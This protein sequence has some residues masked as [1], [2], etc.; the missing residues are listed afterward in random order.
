MVQNHER[1]QFSGGQIEVSMLTGFRGKRE[2]PHHVVRLTL[3]PQPHSKG[4]TELAA[5]SQ[6]LWDIFM[7][8]IL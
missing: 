3:I 8:Q 7:Q 4:G 6:A 5:G 2:V 1:L